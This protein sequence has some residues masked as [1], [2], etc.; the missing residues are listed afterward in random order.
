MRI[1]AEAHQRIGGLHHF[2]GDVAM[3]VKCGDDGHVGADDRADAGQKRAF[4][5]ILV[6][7]DHR[8][9]QVEEHTVKRACGLDSIHD[10]GGDRLIGVACHMGR[11]DRPAPQDRNHVPAR[12]FAMFDGTADAEVDA[13]ARCHQRGA[14]RHRHIATALHEAGHVSRA[15]RKCIGFV[16]KACKRHAFGHLFG[17]APV[18]PSRSATICPVRCLVGGIRSE[19]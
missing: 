2:R 5:V 11:G 13:P 15:W 18:I 16:Q 7:R 6:F 8:A 4:A 14:A 12:A 1:G 10:F 9:V 19:I 17:S 3:Q